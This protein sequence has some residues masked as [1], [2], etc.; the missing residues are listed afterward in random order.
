ML[1]DLRGKYTRQLR[2]RMWWRWSEQ[3]SELSRRARGGK[4]R[5][6]RKGT[7]EVVGVLTL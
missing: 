3:A 5:R 1:L 7:M 4:G 2:R 6:E